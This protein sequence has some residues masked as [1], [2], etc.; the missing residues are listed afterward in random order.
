M[1]HINN[2]KSLST[3]LYP[4]FAFMQSIELGK[5]I[6]RGGFGEVFECVSIDGKPPSHPQ[7]IKIF[8]QQKSSILAQLETIEKLQKKLTQF[9]KTCLQNGLG[10]LE[11]FPAFL[12]CPQFSFRGEREGEPVVGYSANNLTQLGFVEFHQVLEDMDAY[13]YGQV[14]MQ[15]RCRMAWHLA[16]AFDI[17]WQ[18]HFIHADLK[19]E[20]IFIDT[21][22]FRCALIDYDGGAIIQKKD[23]KPSTIGTKQ[24]W[25]APE[26]IAQSIANNIIQISLYSD[27]WSLNMAIHCLLFG[28]TPLVFFR[29]VSALVMRP[30]LQSNRFPDMEFNQSY[31]KPGSDLMPLHAWYCN[32][33]RHTLTPDIAT[34]ICANVQYGF[35]NPT[36]RISA[37]QWAT[38]LK[39]TQPEPMIKYFRCDRQHVNDARPLQIEWEIEHASIVRLNGQVV[40]SQSP[41][42]LTVRNDQVLLLEALSPFGYAKSQIPIEVS[43]KKPTVEWFESD[44]NLRTDG[45][46]IQLR[47]KVLDAAT[48]EI[49]NGVGS[50]Q[51]EATCEV[52]PRLETVFTLTATTWFGIIKTAQLTVKVLASPPN[53]WA[54]KADKKVLTKKEFVRLTWDIE[55]AESI[56]IDQG[57]GD[58]TGRDYV[59]VVTQATTEYTLTATS[60][61]NVTQT[62][63][64]TIQVLQLA[65]RIFS[66]RPSD[67]I[68]SD[69]I[70]IQ[71]TWEVKDAETIEL[72]G[73][74]DVTTQ[75]S[76]FVQPQQDTVYV[77][78]AMGPFGGVSEARQRI[79]T[80]RKAPR[81][82]FRCSSALIRQGKSAKLSWQVTG[83][84]EIVIEPAIGRI[85]PQGTATVT[86][87]ED[88][89]YILLAKS[90]YGIETRAYITVRILRPPTLIRP[91]INL[92]VPPKLHHPIKNKP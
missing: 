7:V 83:A 46:P 88:I 24:E 39:A 86:P 53:I 10:L 26:I 62:A 65:P 57:I 90:Y 70:P 85:G 38:V 59:D 74:G 51:G 48:V 15:Q 23:D 72:L 34:R 84:T 55:N 75:S 56:S 71:L 16:A 30:Y 21:K 87:D 78:R 60:Y 52:S 32:A 41:K 28:F 33:L 80:S 82:A 2:L 63:R 68:I 69:N 29:E 92:L 19:D 5:R 67:H 64:T 36:Q 40:T 8:N 14:S 76:L 25:W 89:T 91:T 1:S 17:L 66:F 4:E 6:G 77:L 12:G 54:F 58:V 44:R 73:H 9:H 49:D 20:A 61:F 22:N 13:G 81:V 27:L 79:T 43:K 45:R 18:C 35:F 37:S 31:I 11:K 50:V 3:G 47:W 42:Q